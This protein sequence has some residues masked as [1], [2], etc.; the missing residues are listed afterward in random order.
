MRTGHSPEKHSRVI[1]EAVEKPL[2][3]ALRTSIPQHPQTLGE[4]HLPSGFDEGL[5]GFKRIAD[6]R[7]MERSGA[8]RNAF[9]INRRSSFQQSNCGLGVVDARADEERS[10]PTAVWTLHE[11]GVSRG[12]RLY[13]FQLSPHGSEVQNSAPRGVAKLREE[14]PGALLGGVSLFESTLEVANALLEL[15]QRSACCIFKQIGHEASVFHQRTE[16]VLF[17]ARRPLS[18]L[19]S[20]HR[21]RKTQSR[22]SRLMGVPPRRRLSSSRVFATQTNFLKR[23]GRLLGTTPSA[24]PLAANFYKDP[25]LGSEN[26]K[27]ETVV[28]LLPPMQKD[29]RESRGGDDGEEDPKFSSLKPGDGPI[30]QSAFYSL[31]A[32]SDSS[33]L[34]AMAFLKIRG[35]T[36]R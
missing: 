25:L 22:G 33:F 10:F 13:V 16:L 2:R 9:S 27:R 5:Q 29:F 14:F 1:R 21:R 18:R 3:S 6:Y 23:E 7:V 4:S 32:L 35:R 31:R 20:S 28:S 12:E 8:C 15:L 11:V 30:Q 17:R 36:L 19:S 26:Q 34:H 24:A